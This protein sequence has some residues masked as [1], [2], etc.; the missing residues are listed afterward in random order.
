MAAIVEHALFDN[1]PLKALSR[2]L[3]QFVARAKCNT[4]TSRKSIRRREERKG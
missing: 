4:F 3:G 2:M 1:S